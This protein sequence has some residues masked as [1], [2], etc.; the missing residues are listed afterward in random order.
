VSYAVNQLV[1]IA[2]RAL[3]LSI[4]DPFL[5]MSCIDRLG[6]AL[7][8][9]A[10]KSVPPSYRYDERGKLRLITSSFSFEG[11]VDRSFN[12][13]RQDAATDVAVTL[14]L[15][16]TLAAIA[17]VVERN[18]RRE[19]I[20]RQGEMIKRAGDRFRSREARSKR[21]FSA[22][23]EPEADP[24]DRLSKPAHHLPLMPEMPKALRLSR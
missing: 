8:R 19:A 3:S 24:G 1:A 20:R 17:G 10:Q 7:I 9:L 21:Y 2:I 23:S 5:A 12:Q 13:I 14:R 11:V 6:A 16:E 22:L 4:N 15:L 18:E